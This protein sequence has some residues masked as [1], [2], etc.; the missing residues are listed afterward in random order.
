MTRRLG[1]LLLCTI[2]MLCAGGTL[3]A[4]QADDPSILTINRIFDSGDFNGESFGPARWLKDGSG[5]TTLEDSND[6]DKGR[7]IVRYDPNTGQREVLVSAEQLIPKGQSEPLRIDGYTWSDD[8]ARLL[9][10]TNSQRVWRANTRGDYWVLTLANGRLRKLGGDAPASSL[11]FAKFS[12]NGRKVAYVRQ[13]NLYVQ[14]VGDLEVTQLTHDGSETIVNG[15]SDWVYEEEFDLR[16]G[17]RWSPNGKWIAYWQFDTS[18]VPMFHMI[19][20][21]TS[22]YPEI[23]TFAY[24]KAGQMNSACRVGVVHVE[25]GSTRWFELSD[26]PRNHYIPKMEWADSSKEIVVQ[27]LNRL[28][29]RNEVILANVR[30]GTSRTVM[31]ERD[32]AWLDVTDCLTWFEDGSRFT[33]LSERDGWRRLYAISRSGRKATPLTP[34]ACDVI[35]LARVDKESGWAYYIASPEDPTQRYLYRVVLDGTGSAERIT[36]EDRP[37]M[38]SYDISPDAK[39]AFHTVSSFGCPPVISLVSLPDHQ[40]VRVLADN[41]KL[42]QTLAEVKTGPTEF[43]RVDIGD[44]VELDGWCIRPPQF[45]PNG[46]YPTLFHVY[47]EPAGQTVL[48]R[49]GGK[50]YLWHQML[51]QQGYVVVSVDNRGTPAPRGRQ[52]RKCVYRQIGILASADQA[53][54]VRRIIETR[55]YVDPNAIGI[56]GWSG[57][58]SMTLNAMFRYPELYRTGM[59]IAFVSD[60][61]FYDTI[62]QERYMGL[63]DDNAEGYKNGSPITF[64]HQLGGN[65]LLVHGTAD[66]N[67]HYQNCEALVNKLVEHDKPFTMMVYPNR[68][69]GIG[70]GRNTTVHLYS[71]LTRFLQENL[72]STQNGGDG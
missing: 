31:T 15:T 65:L 67:V 39:W 17:F 35:D 57:G 18:G 61:R 63:P 4:G 26:D 19:D 64:A 8:G 37:G 32:A 62:Y 56:W 6:I 51:A 71:L 2:V 29:N 21:T 12:P 70:E 49:W 13:N 44:G 66:D 28:Q 22:L 42:R 34:A 3:W 50:G 60:E 16:D 54:A 10:F 68:T 55:P 59:A 11:M 33:W 53:A 23:T 9:I 1:L 30:K 36:P 27:H 58:G 48:D 45:D 47:G 24:P 69:H 38:H 5:Y 46:R 72:P 43:F 25:G 40:T 20:N 41:A 7:D 52:W 14:N